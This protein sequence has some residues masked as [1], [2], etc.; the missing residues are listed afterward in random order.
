MGQPG[1]VHTGDLYFDGLEKLPDDIAAE[2][3]ELYLMRKPWDERSGDFRSFSETKHPHSSRWN[4][5]ASGKWE[6]G[7]WVRTERGSGPYG[8]VSH[9][10]GTTA[11]VAYLYWRRF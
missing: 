2:M 7:R 11:K 8:N 6:K 1:D 10:F 5:V 9:I 4:W 3:R